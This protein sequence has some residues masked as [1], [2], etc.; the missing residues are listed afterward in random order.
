MPP[1][2]V[3]D[4]SQLQTLEVL[5]VHS[6]AAAAAAASVAAACLS[7]LTGPCASLLVSVSHRERGRKEKAL[8]C[9]SAPRKSR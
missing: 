1:L 6:A 4:E 5:L 7:V 9:G 8:G 2:M 3:P